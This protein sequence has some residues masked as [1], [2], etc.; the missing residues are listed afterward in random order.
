M[1]AESRGLENMCNILK[2]LKALNAQDMV[3][4]MNVSNSQEL[5]LYTRTGIQV[6]LGDGEEM[7]KKLQWMKSAV[8]DLE[9][10]GETRGRL[11]V[12]SGN[13][14]DFMPQ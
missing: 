4:E 13:K 7:D 8:A 2:T 9:S 3:S 12:S 5:Y 10:R 1:G 14:A 6:V 11:D